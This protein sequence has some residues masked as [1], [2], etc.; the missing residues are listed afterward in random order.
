ML[1]H[2]IPVLKSSDFET[3]DEIINYVISIIKNNQLINKVKVK[4]DKDLCSNITQAHKDQLKTHNIKIE[5]TSNGLY[6][7]LDDKDNIIVFSYPN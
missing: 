6:P 5:S 1:K 2:I 7:S 3:I 4:D